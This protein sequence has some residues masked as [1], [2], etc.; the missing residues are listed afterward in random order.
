MPEGLEDVSR[1]PYLVA[2]LVRRGWN[3]EDLKKV[4]GL[5]FV[6]VFAEAERVAARLSRERPPSTASFETFDRS[7]R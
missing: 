6:R 4:V 2:E 1:Y 7:P 5:N 3:D